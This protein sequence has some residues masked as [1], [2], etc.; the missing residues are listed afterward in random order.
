[1]TKKRSLIV[2]LVAFAALIHPLPHLVSF[3]DS[4]LCML[5]VH[6][7]CVNVPW[8]LQSK[9]VIAAYECFGRAGAQL[10]MFLLPVVITL[11]PVAFIYRYVRKRDFETICADCTAHSK[12]AWTLLAL[13]VLFSVARP[14]VLISCQ[15]VVSAEEEVSL[16]EMPACQEPVRLELCLCHPDTEELTKSLMSAGVISTQLVAS[17]KS[18]EGYRLMTRESK[19]GDIV[20]AVYVS[21]QAE[22]TEEDV[23]S[24]SVVRDTVIDDYLVKCYLSSSANRRLTELT[25]AYKPHGKKNPRDKGRQLAVVVNGRLMTAPVIQVEI[26]GGEFAICGNFL[27]EEAIREILREFCIMPAWKWLLA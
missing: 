7:G 22:L 2:A 12:T 16:D 6:A 8:G 27:R 17:A 25:R 13:F 14:D 23:V 10:A 1:M 26:N 15:G 3:A 9:L 20:E 24:A 18:V 4:L 19:N 21:E 11:I 5:L